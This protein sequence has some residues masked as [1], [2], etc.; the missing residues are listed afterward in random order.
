MP[1]ALVGCGPVSVEKPAKLETSTIAELAKPA[2]VLVMTKYSG[3]VTV[4]D[5][6]IPQNRLGA[7]QNV[8][9]RGLMSGAIANN[10]RALVEAAVIE[11][12]SNW[13]QYLAASGGTRNV[14]VN[15]TGVGSG[16]FV[17]PDGYIVTNAHV[18]SEDEKVLKQQIAQQALGRL[19][20]QDLAELQKEVGAVSDATK[21]RLKAAVIDFYTSNMSIGDIK[22]DVSTLYGVGVPGMNVQP[23]PSAVEVIESGLGTPIPGK[24]VAILKA[25]GDNFP[26]LPLGDDKAL[27][28][29]E[30]VFP[31]GYPAD[32]TF[33]QAFDPSS[34]TESSLT[35][36]LVS[37][38]KTMEG[39][40]TAI[41]TDAAIRGGN[42]G[43]P[44]L[45]SK[46]EVIGISTFG[47]RDQQTGASAQGA[48]FLVPTSII[49]EF[50]GRT[51]VTPSAGPVT[52]KWTESVLLME[53]G[54]HKAAQE[55]LNEVNAL[56][57]GMPWVQNAISTTQKEIMAGNDKTPNPM[58]PLVIG[59]G[60]VA[61]V[62][63]GG[64]VAMS[65][66]KKPA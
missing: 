15:I 20:Q 60:V 49:K 58:I 57:P 65:R 8:L 51:N 9:Q 2:T 56:R 40:W 34:V 48:N 27:K 33:F 21:E 7:L 3:N 25:Q 32:A 64:F 19:L 17:T 59:G 5:V 31:L 35:S 42:S 47:L 1:L 22:R 43:G 10:E 55:R 61:I 16:F 6:Y 39:G 41:Q 54:Y 23:K 45:N 29:G 13:R 4:P 28:T 44:A 37:A 18:V 63:I 66:R 38:Q 46:G 11:L 12:A 36:G 53:K 14:G 50:L 30:Q 26:T 52:E 62:A 24:D